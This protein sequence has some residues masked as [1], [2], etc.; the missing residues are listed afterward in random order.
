MPRG[1]SHQL[2]IVHESLNQ[3]QEDLNSTIAGD[4]HRKFVLL[5]WRS[6]KSC[7]DIRKVMSEVRRIKMKFGRGKPGTASGARA[8]TQVLEGRRDQTASG[9]KKEELCKSKK[10]RVVSKKASL[11]GQQKYEHI[12]KWTQAIQ[13][14]ELAIVGF[15]PVG[16]T[17]KQGKQLYKKAR[18]V[19][20]R[21]A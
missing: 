17:A 8:K 3:I 15:C 11:A 1:L 12:R 2:D 18:E 7:E 10:G 14:S 9:Q 13:T 6:G 5:M 16:G 20:F 4:R 21:M 19:L